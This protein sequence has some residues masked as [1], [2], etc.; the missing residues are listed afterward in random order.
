MKRAMGDDSMKHNVHTITLIISNMIALILSIG[1]DL[2][3]KVSII[4]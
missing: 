3:A 1:F 4:L 2:G